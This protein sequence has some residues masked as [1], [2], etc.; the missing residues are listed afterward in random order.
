MSAPGLQRAR[1]ELLSGRMN[2]RALSVL[3]LDKPEVF[4]GLSRNQ[5]AWLSSGTAPDEVTV[6][7]VIQGG[8]LGFKPSDQPWDEGG[9]ERVAAARLSKWLERLVLP[10]QNILIDAPHL[11]SRFPSLAVVEHWD[12]T[13]RLGP[14]ASTGLNDERLSAHRFTANTWLSRPAWLWPTVSEDRSIDEVRDP[15]SPVKL[16]EFFTED[17]SVFRDPSWCRPFAADVEPF[18]R[19]FATRP[20]NGRESESA[21]YA[22]Q[23]GLGGVQYQPQ[24]RFA[25]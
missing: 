12:E 16:T 9:I 3:G 10:G 20:A 6:M 14:D 13:T 22:G 2:D 8:R 23:Y 24:L 21:P 7:S 19:R 1:E 11:V 17:S 15:F 25:L 5:L 4:N 18:S